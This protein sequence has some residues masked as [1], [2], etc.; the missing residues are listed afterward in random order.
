MGKSRRARATGPRLHD[1][2]CHVIL[3]LGRGKNSCFPDS[4][5]ENTVCLVPDTSAFSLPLKS[6]PENLASVYHSDI[7]LGA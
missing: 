6:S 3:D 7:D 5:K 2:C 1:S 4:T